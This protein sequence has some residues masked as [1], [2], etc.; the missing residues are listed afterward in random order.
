MEYVAGGRLGRTKSPFAEE[1]TT[2]VKPIWSALTVIVAFGRTAPLASF[3]DPKIVPEVTWASTEVPLRQRTIV[4]TEHTMLASLPQKILRI[5][6]PESFAKRS[7]RF[8]NTTHAPNR[9]QS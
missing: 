9:K 1:V 5:I 6:P 4:I 2:R 8:G 7:S 3:T